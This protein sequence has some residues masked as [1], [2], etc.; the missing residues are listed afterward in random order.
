VEASSDEILNSKIG[1]DEIHLYT[2]PAGEHADFLKAVKSR[3]DPYFPVEIGHRV[4]TV[5]HLGN[6][7]VKLGRKLKWDPEKEQ[8]IGD[9]SANEMRQ[10]RPMRKPWK[11]PVA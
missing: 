10:I 3:Q 5:C 11:F 1:P 6:I 9:D 4:S 8:F 2:N 7:A